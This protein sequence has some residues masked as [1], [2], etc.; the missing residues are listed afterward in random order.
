MNLPKTGITI[1]KKYQ[2]ATWYSGIAYQ[3]YEKAL[4]FLNVSLLLAL[5]FERNGYTVTTTALILFNIAML[6][7]SSVSGLVLV[8]IK[9]AQIVNSLANNQNPEIMEILE[10]V[11]QQKGK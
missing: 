7:V 3:E 1:W 9:T 4:K 2:Q 10:W 6:I 8:K 11:R 5:V